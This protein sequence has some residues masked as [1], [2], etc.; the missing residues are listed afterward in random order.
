VPSRRA[1]WPTLDSVE[2]LDVAE[3]PF[4][5]ETHP[6]EDALT[7]TRLAKDV[8]HDPRHAHLTSLK[9]LGEALLKD[10]GAARSKQ[11]VAASQDGLV[12]TE[13]EE[14]AA[15]HVS[16]ANDGRHLVPPFELA[17]LTR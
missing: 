15:D 9:P 12:G 11:I 13:I 2:S 17:Q 7:G 8:G 5:V 6:D 3:P 4:L 1:S 14:I 10:N 16:H